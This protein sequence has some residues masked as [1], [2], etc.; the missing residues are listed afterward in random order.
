MQIPPLDRVECAILHDQFKPLDGNALFREVERL[1]IGLGY[2][3][4]VQLMVSSTY[5]DIH[6]HAGGHR[7]LVSQNE[8][9]LAPDGFRNALSTPYTGFALPDAQE[10]VHRHKANTFVTVAKGMLDT[11]LF[12]SELRAIAGDMFDKIDAASGF[13]TQEEAQRAMTLCHEVCKLV[14]GHNPASALHWCVSDNLVPQSFFEGT[15][16]DRDY[17][18][19]NIR[20][21]LTSSANRIGDG[22]P[23][24]M[25]VNGSQWV[26]GKMIEFE[27]APVPFPWMMEVVYGFIRMC[28]LRGSILPD[29][30]TFSTEGEDWTVA[31]FHEKIEGHAA[32]EKVRLVV[33][34]A[35]QFGIYGDTTAARYHTYDSAEDVRRRA[36]EEQHEVTAANDPQSFDRR[37][38]TDPVA[39]N[40][41]ESTGPAAAAAN[42]PDRIRVIKTT[43]PDM[44]ELR[45][46]AKRSSERGAAPPPAE[47]GSKGLL[48]R[49]RVWFSRP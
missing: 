36:E 15:A 8:E 19:L 6:V 26:I 2:A 34:N 46:L 40:S 41:H 43:R 3:D 44:N 13:V 27:E 32:F 20:P 14:I 47:R 18:L 1:A 24:G 33:V 48:S 23:L 21:F 12:S 45:A 16:K 11:K 38:D 10:I 9:P 37:A 31:V 29:R 4:D 17:T 49:A 30:N 25:V 22:L 28:Q 5:K 42:D 7:I 39:I 35:P